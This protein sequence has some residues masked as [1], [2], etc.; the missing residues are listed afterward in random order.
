MTDTAAQK[1]EPVYFD[2]ARF[3]R[4]AGEGDPGALPMLH[5][6]LDH[7]EQG[8]DLAVPA[9]IEASKNVAEMLYARLAIAIND[10]LASAHLDIPL[11]D[12]DWLAFH[13]R[14]LA[15]IFRMAWPDGPE[16]VFRR[17]LDAH[18]D[19]ATGVGL[20][21]VLVASSVAASNE[22]DWRDLLE[23]EPETALPFFLANFT[24]RTLLDSEAERRRDALFALAPLVAEIPL[25]AS[26]V[27]VLSEAWMLCSY[28]TAPNR[29]EI[30]RHLN[31]MVQELLTPIHPE[32]LPETRRREDRPTIVVVAEVLLSRHAI[33]KTYAYF[34]GQLRNRFRLVLVTMAGMVDNR[35]AALFDE[36]V[37]FEGS[38]GLIMKIAE[39]I[40]QLSPAIVYFPSVGMSL[41]TV[42]LCN[43]RW[44][45]I[46]IVSTGHPA[47]SQSPA[48]DYMVTGHE[49]FGGEEYFSEQAILL[50]SGGAL[51]VPEAATP[52]APRV[53][54]APEI[55]RI[56]VPAAP[57]KL[58]TWFIDL[59]Q[60][61]A[62][63]GG[64]AVEW[65][66]FPNLT[67]LRHWDCRR[68]IEA[69][70]PGARVHPCLDYAA[71]LDHIN[72][73]DV[74]FGTYPFGGANTSLD[75]FRQGLPTLVLE[76]P[77]PHSR[78][79][80]RFIRLFGLPEWL[81]AGSEEEYEKAA[82]RLIGDDEERCQ[83]ARQIL[84]ADPD[85]VLYTEEHDLYP[86]LT[87][88]Q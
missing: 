21:K 66:F 2:L 64:R 38:A 84:D 32:E 12:C 8:G 17:V 40:N 57:M 13:D 22:L 1:E 25:R 78:T 5:R 73:C 4:L 20:R 10:L 45:P 9:R 62:E 33:Y 63:K 15:A 80:K 42:L 11:E 60:R 82:L 77:E 29:H 88:E 75:A 3:E 70:L 65:W 72:R 46:Q 36:T 51:F 59:C 68:Q 28:A 50:R 56:A 34:L 30:K 67:G 6:L 79:D 14:H 83:L 35:A 16:R 26:T 43:L 86:M 69:R 39:K 76:G 18:G 47:T 74:R 85:R 48:I 37:A 23:R 19:A 53:R 55:L 27:P 58:N 49:H 31:S 87:A 71:Y 52:I 54:G 24:H 44:A 7:I 41:V 61:V 81:I